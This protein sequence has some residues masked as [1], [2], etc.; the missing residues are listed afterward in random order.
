MVENWTEE[1]EYED[2][3]KED[4]EDKDENKEMDEIIEAKLDS[5]VEEVVDA[6][7]GVSASTNEDDDYNEVAISN[8]LVGKKWM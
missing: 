4:K 1:A 6:V 5:N 2:D 3:N 8:T 7:L